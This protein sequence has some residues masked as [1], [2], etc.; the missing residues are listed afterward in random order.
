M[1]YY[2]RLYYTFYRFLLKLDDLFSMQRETPRVETALILTI[3]TG[4]NVITILGLLSEFLGTSILSGKKVY[5]MLILS[6]I[7]FINLLLVFYKKR[8]KKVEEKLSLEWKAA[9]NKN[10]L[11]ALG[12][13]IVTVT[14]FCLTIQYIKY[15]PSLN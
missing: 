11:L 6:P 3:L 10:I 2:D 7:V 14:F 4:F 5:V 15:H 9:K 12:Y 1:K 13:I 8:Y